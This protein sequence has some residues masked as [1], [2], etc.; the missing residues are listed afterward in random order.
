MHTSAVTANRSSFA[1]EL[2]QARNG[3]R[4]ALGHLFELARPYLLQIA[5]EELAR[6]LFAKNSVL[7][8][9]QDAFL[10]AQ[11]DFAAFTGDDEREFLGWL[12]RILLHNLA[13]LRKRYAT[14]TRDLS[15]ELPLSAALASGP[16]VCNE[17]SPCDRLAEREQ[18]HA[19]EKALAALPRNYQTVIQLRNEQD[20]SFAEIA[21]LMGK[22]T[23]DAARKLWIRAVR[24]LQ[25]SVAPYS[26]P[27]A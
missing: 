9:V 21:R 26:P 15:R 7:D 6:T 2:T 25:T 13:D 19:L 4:E 27:E 17:P 5:A 3:S 22:P 8:C 12:R 1:L 24:S 23:E 14:R 20:R 16:L 18:S 11:R 10:E